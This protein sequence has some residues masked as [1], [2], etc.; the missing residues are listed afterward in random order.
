MT[1]WVRGQDK[2]SLIECKTIDVLNRFNEFYIVANYID[3]GEVENYSN[4]GQYSSKR[5]QIKVLDMIQNHVETYSN[6]VFQMPQDDEV[7]A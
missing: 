3:F 6:K 7:K 5:K 4:L 1:I 2:T